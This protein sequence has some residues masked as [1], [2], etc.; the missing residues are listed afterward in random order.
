MPRSELASRGEPGKVLPNGTHIALNQGTLVLG[1]HIA[2]GGSAYIR[3]GELLK[4]NEPKKDVAAKIFSQFSIDS[5]PLKLQEPETE[6]KVL[7]FF[8]TVLKHPNILPFELYD[9]IRN[10][11]AFKVPEGSKTPEI[12]MPDSGI[13]IILTMLAGNSLH[14]RLTGSP[15]KPDEIT[16]AIGGVANALISAHDF[17]IVH[18]DVKPHNIL[19]TQAQDNW[20][21]GD[22]GTAIID[23]EKRFLLTSSTVRATLEYAAPER[24][25][26]PRLG[27]ESDQYA[28]AVVLYVAATKSLPFPRTGSLHEQEQAIYNG[29][30]KFSDTITDPNQLNIMLPFEQVTQK[31]MHINRDARYG[32][33]REFNQALAEAGDEAGKIAKTGKKSFGVKDIIFEQDQK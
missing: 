7:Q 23:D 1:G 27:P 26:S 17:N 9:T 28:I 19:Q 21:L 24:F 10:A 5:F 8:T 3:R 4:P 16:F 12:H 33:M 6:A 29:A 18:G 2:E 31:G 15:M 11:G 13:P 22:W 14:T 32:D 25:S 30:R 20:M